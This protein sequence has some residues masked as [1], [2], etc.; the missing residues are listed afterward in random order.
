MHIFGVLLLCFY[1]WSEFMWRASAMPYKRF[2]LL[3]QK[4]RNGL[5][6]STIQWST[7]VRPCASFII[8]WETSLWVV[9]LRIH[10]STHWLELIPYRPD[11]F[12]KSH[13][14]NDT[15]PSL[16]YVQ[17]SNKWATKLKSIK[18]SLADGQSTKINILIKTQI[19]QTT[20]PK[21]FSGVWVYLG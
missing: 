11:I 21:M 1:S 14:Q 15:M 18:S 9:L 5:W 2:V 6:D 16:I 3:R 4:S 12:R 20:K 17:S 8:S 7:F 10:D 19:Q 13:S